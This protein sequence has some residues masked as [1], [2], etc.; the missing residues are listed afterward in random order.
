VQ[1]VVLVE[2]SC[3]VEHPDAADRA[4]QNQVVVRC[5]G[6]GAREREERI[7]AVPAR[8]LDRLAA[9]T[10]APRRVSGAGQL[11]ALAGLGAGIRSVALRDRIDIRR[12]SRRPR[13]RLSMRKRKGEPVRE[14]RVRVTE[15][16]SNRDDTGTFPGRR[17]GSRS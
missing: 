2:D 13:E 16:V 6:Q 17:S 15:G 3:A 1:G 4:P 11:V 8:D 14:R 7:G 9:P 5:G 12:F 10:P